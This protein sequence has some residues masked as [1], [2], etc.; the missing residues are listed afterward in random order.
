MSEPIS[1]R[2]HGAIVTALMTALRANP[3]GGRLSV[4]IML[5]DG[6][7]ERLAFPISISGRLAAVPGFWTRMERE[8]SD[9]VLGAIQNP[10]LAETA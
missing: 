5:D 10:P 6:R 3:R 8:I 1:I 7:V 4:S 9:S 2:D